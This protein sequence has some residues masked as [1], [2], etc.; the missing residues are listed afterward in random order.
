MQPPQVFVIAPF[1]PEGRSVQDTVRRA[2]EEAGFGVVQHRDEFRPGAE[3]TSNILDG[4]RQ[5][6][7]VIADV[8]RQNPNVLYEV[9]FAHALRKPTILLFN[10]K[11]DYNLPTDLAG[12]QYIAYDLVNLPGLAD[13]VKSETKALTLERS[14]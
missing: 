7:L 9:G 2:V 8:S 10:I 1:N 4:I 6:D 3:M 5:A 11:S 12:L 13:R 14:A